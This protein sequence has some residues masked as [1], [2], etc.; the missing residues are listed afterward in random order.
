MN[1]TLELE[2]KSN[3]ADKVINRLLMIL[4]KDPSLKLKRKGKKISIADIEEEGNKDN[5]MLPGKPMT[6]GQLKKEAHEGWEE[7]KRG[8]SI[9]MEELIEEMKTW[10]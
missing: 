10:K 3:R 1:H 9:S 6:W 8:E 2:I 7:Y 4:E 5:M